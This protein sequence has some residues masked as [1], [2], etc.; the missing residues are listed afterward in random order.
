[1]PP[2]PRTWWRSP[3]CTSR[4]SRCWRSS[5]RASLWRWLPFARRRRTRA[6]RLVVRPRR[7]GRLCAARRILGA[8]AAHL[9]DARACSRWRGS[10]RGTSARAASGRWRWS[11]CCCSMRSRRCPRASGCRSWRWASSSRSSQRALVDARDVAGARVERRAPAVRH[12]AGARAAH[13]R[14]VRRVS[15]AGLCGQSRR[16]S[17]W[18]H[19]CSCRWC[20]PARSRCWWRRARATLFFSARGARCTIGSG[21][22]L[23]WAADRELAQWRADAVARG[24]SRS[25]R[26]RRW[27]CCG[28]GRGRCG[29]PR[30]AL[31][32]PLLFAPSRMPA[33]GTARVSVLDAGRGTAV[34]VA[35]AFARAAVRYRRQLEHA[36]HAPARSSCCRR[37]MRCGRTRVDL[38]VLPALNEDRAQGA[39]LLAFEREVGRVLV[40]GGWPATSL[41]VRTLHG[42]AIS[43]GTASSSGSSRRARAAATACCAC[44]W[45]RTRCC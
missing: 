34:L 36:R 35:H 37:S 23:V 21:P 27:C 32:L 10:R 31:A 24:G 22:A 33:P 45:A 29:C 11:P 4:C 8:H 41:P 39:A 42:L 44:R 16:D 40:G 30:P 5:R 13:V 43:T 9:A 15:L 14:G 28:A 19:S 3:D 38:L 25:R 17:R 7:R 1:M 2:A 26:P 12:H 6:V 20:W 18:F